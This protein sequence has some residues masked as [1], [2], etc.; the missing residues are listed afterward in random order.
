MQKLLYLN[1]ST[2]VYLLFTLCGSQ[3]FFFR[4]PC[5]K[6]TT[7]TFLTVQNIF[8]THQTLKSLYFQLREGKGNRKVQQPSGHQLHHT[9]HRYNMHNIIVICAIRISRG[10]VKLR[11]IKIN[12]QTR[13]YKDKWPN[14]TPCPN[15]LDGKWGW[16]KM[17]Y[18]TDINSY[19]AAKDR[20]F[21]SFQ[22][23]FNQPRVKETS[24]LARLLNSFLW[25]E[26]WGEGCH[27]CV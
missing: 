27:A 26:T 16:K 18:W 7:I 1:L 15:S 19:P 22:D 10:L 21:C 24:V 9:G 13:H 6:H 8:C 5:I 4:W 11:E 12:P 23:R 14:T 2:R 20:M 25:R 3:L 17:L